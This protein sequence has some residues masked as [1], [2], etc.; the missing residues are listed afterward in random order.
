M[1]EAVKNLGKKYTDDQINTL[2]QRHFDNSQVL[3]IMS[4]NCN[5]MITCCLLLDTL[6]M[7]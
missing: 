3:L 5:E 2:A 6:S 4:Y 7:K 1:E